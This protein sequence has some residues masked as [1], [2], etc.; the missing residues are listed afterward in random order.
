MYPYPGV[1]W[2]NDR[3]RMVS[4]RENKGKHGAT[5]A[6]SGFSGK[7]DMAKAELFELQC[8]SVKVPVASPVNGARRIKRM[9]S[10][11]RQR[12]ATTE[13][14]GA[15]EYTPMSILRRLASQAIAR[16]KS[17]SPLDK[18]LCDYR[19]NSW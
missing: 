13:D 19:R 9:D 8:G 18:Y 6:L 1:L 4:F 2:C 14:R 3:H 15:V 11:M 5:G 16:T 17:L 12:L 10:F 7:T